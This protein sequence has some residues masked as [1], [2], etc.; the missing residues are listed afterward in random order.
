MAWPTISGWFAKTEAPQDVPTRVGDV[1]EKTKRFLAVQN[2]AADITNTKGNEAARAFV[3]QKIAMTEEKDE[4]AMLLVYK[5][6]ISSDVPG[7]PL[8]Y[9]QEAEIIAPSFESA[10]ALSTYYQLAGDNANALKYAKLMLERATP[11]YPETY[12]D[13]YAAA[14]KRIKYL[15]A[16]Q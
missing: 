5:S 1:D 14:Q 2:E 7:A 10:S 15:E 4:K 8:S 6:T 16:Q 11:D 12:P 13:D 3:D 9:A